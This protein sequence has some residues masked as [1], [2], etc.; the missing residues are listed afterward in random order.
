MRADT[1]YV[2]DEC[3]EFIPARPD[4]V[5]ARAKDHLRRRMRRGTP[6]RSPEVVRDF[7]TVTLGDRDCEYFCL[8][9]LDG[10]HRLLRFVELFRGTIDHAS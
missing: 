7:L 2:R 10:H 1:V 8:I 5:L 6:L 3:G 9:C 4:V